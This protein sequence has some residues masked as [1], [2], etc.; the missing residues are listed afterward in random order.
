MLPGMRPTALLIVV[1][2]GGTPKARSA[3]EVVRVPDVCAPSMD[4]EEAEVDMAAIWEG[5]R[6][7]GVA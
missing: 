4:D 6:N 1:T 5:R 3:G 2:T 7:R